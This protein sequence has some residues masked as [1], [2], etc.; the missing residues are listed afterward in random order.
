MKTIHG[1]F[2]LA[3]LK[4]SLTFIGPIAMNILSKS[5]AFAGIK[6][7]FASPASA[8]ANKV[9]PFPGA[10]SRRIPLGI[11]I[12]RFAYSTGFFIM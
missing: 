6:F 7:T 9:L 8:F 10:P 3:F 5:V 11:R 4:R 12:P 1:A 2:L